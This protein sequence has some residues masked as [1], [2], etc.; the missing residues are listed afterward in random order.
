[1]T[2]QEELEHLNRIIQDKLS[3]EC[4]EDICSQA[5]PHCLVPKDEKKILSSPSS[6]QVPSFRIASKL[7]QVSMFHLSQKRRINLVV[8]VAVTTIVVCVNIIR[9]FRRDTSVH[10]MVAITQQFGKVI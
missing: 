3:C 4:V 8:A 1:M 10:S 7:S 2:K 9:L 5:L 6:L